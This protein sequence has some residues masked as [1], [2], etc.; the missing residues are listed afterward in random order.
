[1]TGRE[2]VFLNRTLMG[3]N[4]AEIR[5][6]FDEIITFAGIERYINTPVKRYSSGMCVMLA[7]DVAAHM[8][9]EILIGEELLAVEDAEFQK[10][11]LG[12][13]KEGSINEGR[14]VLLV[15]AGYRA[16]LSVFI[17]R[18]LWSTYLLICSKTFH[19]SY[20]SKPKSSNALN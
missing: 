1:M 15:T 16:S 10:K 11:C 13:M 8:E 20:I 14:T 3:M 9:P 5:K 17:F 12:K 4:R 18:P 7:F 6:K 19:F 2:N